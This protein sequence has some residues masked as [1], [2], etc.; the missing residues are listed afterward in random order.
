ML[1]RVADAAQHLDGVLGALERGRRCQRCRGRD[2]GRELLV[3]GVQ[4][5]GVPRERPGRLQPA[6]RIGTAVLHGLE[7]AD[8][9]AELDALRGVGGR[10][11]HTPRRHPDALRGADQRDGLLHRSRRRV[12]APVRRHARRGPAS[13][14]PAA[15]SGPL[16]GAAPPAPGPDPPGPTPPTPGPRRGRAPGTTRPGRRRRPGPTGPP[17]PPRARRPATAPPGGGRTGPAPWPRPPSRGTGRGPPPAPTPP[18]PCTGR[19]ACRPVRR[20][21]P[22]RPVRPNPSRS[23][24]P[25]RGAAPRPRP[26]ARPAPPPTASG[27][28]ASDGPRW[29]VRCRPGPART[30]PSVRSWA[31]SRDGHLSVAGVMGGSP[32]AADG[33]TA[34]RRCR[35]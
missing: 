26:P 4:A 2:R 10:G 22:A 31:A 7:L 23:A 24:R 21:P 35:G 8:G 16:R 13:P 20:P 32:A 30:G 5:G 9:P 25:R 27:P 18:P 14:G 34:P 19:P 33:G 6:Q 12:E 11:V 17:S 3:V 1:P 29:P 28:P 15:G